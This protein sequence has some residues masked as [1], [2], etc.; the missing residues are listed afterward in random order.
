MG[1][2]FPRQKRHSAI[3]F[4]RR[5]THRR[6]R[7]LESPF[8]GTAGSPPDLPNLPSLKAGMNGAPPPVPTLGNARK[9]PRMTSA[10]SCCGGRL[11][12]QVLLILRITVGSGSSTSFDRRFATAPFVG[13]RPLSF[14]IALAIANARWLRSSSRPFGLS[15]VRFRV[16]VGAGV[17][18][19]AVVGVDVDASMGGMGGDALAM[20]ACA[21]S[22]ASQ[23]PATS[24][25]GSVT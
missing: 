17:D 16:G 6:I 21:Y 7:C 13:T 2:I 25:D 10:G 8:E 5:K 9:K 1:F 19:G 15:F 23:I 3:Y 22:F 14:R 20:V 18:A 11:H 24:T 12:Y 4:H